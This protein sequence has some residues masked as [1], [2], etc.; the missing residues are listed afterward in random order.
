MITQFI[1]LRLRETTRS[2][3]FNKNLIINILFALSMLYLM[4]C[5][6]MLGFLLDRLLMEA[7]PD[8]NPVELFNRVLLYYFG[9]E[10]LI[11][12][13]MQSTPAMSIT[14]FL[15]LPVKR[16][17]LM[18]Y[19]LARS[20]ISPLNYISFL[21]FIPFAIRAV[22]VIYTGAAACWWLLT[23]FLL[24]LFVI[25]ANTY[26]KRQLVVKPVV[27]LCCGLAFVALIGLDIFNI[28]S[29]S[30]ISVSL[31]N[32]VLE[33]PLWIILPVMLVGGVYL[34]NYRFL[35][36]HSYPE[37]IDR[38]STKKQ[39]TV[40]NLGFMSRF[41]IIGELIGMEL[42]LILRHKRTKSILYMTI[43]FLLY[44]LLFYSNPTYNDNIM[45]LVFIAIFITGSIMLSYGQY[46]VAWE[47][48]F[49]DGILTRD[50]S[51]LDY[52]RGKYYML[53][54]FCIAGFVVSSPYVFFG[55]K[56]L[57]L[58]TA[59]FL[60]NIGFNAIVLL[61]FAQYNR[62][63]MELSAGTAFSWQ[64]A[65]ATHFITLLPAMLLPVI[66]AGVFS[67]MGLENWGLGVLA[68]M[69]AIGV[70]C[71]KWFLL[72]LSRRFAQTKYA[73]AEGFRGNG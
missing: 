4:V 32:A 44:G 66:I 12:F 17:F 56:F 2:A 39:V 53:V 57:W 25:Y 11:R 29:L 27:T 67:W 13:L 18:H 36:I 51:L 1:K 69:G 38:T 35:M 10:L 31:F 70:L 22:A 62:K 45:W 9:L 7:A 68:L 16:S 43:I 14:P 26:I 8:S 49:Y 28:Y 59:C 46:I 48:K 3:V 65:S 24:I 73:Q 50:C 23:L 72:I 5:F 64:G 34:L 61:W 60:F 63:R 21:I 30:D 52:F 42:K 41:G 54:S 40:R 20:I 55:I 15:H 19:L 58:Q 71:H 37:E 47:G 6:L 33:Q